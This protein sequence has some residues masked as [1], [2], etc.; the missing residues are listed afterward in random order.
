MRK[1]VI[2]SVLVAGLVVAVICLLATRNT[3]TIETADAI[4][5][6]SEQTGGLPE[7]IIGDPNKAKVILYEYADFGCSHCADTNK[8]INGLMEKYDGEIAL[9]FRYYD[10]GQFPNSPAAARAATAAQIQGYFKEYKD[11]LFSNQ[12]EWYYADKSELADLFTEYFAKVSDDNGD[13]EKFRQDMA[14]DAV[15]TRLNFER[16][17][18]RK[19]DLHG[20]PLLRING[21]QIDPSE[22]T[23]AIKTSL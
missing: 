11:L 17:L 22:L 10:I 13:L 2:I 18:G 8:T 3:D 6:A 5:P 1:K 7:K 16:K 19:A 15:K 14:S 21:E 20:T 12:V 4:Y 9:V 23:E